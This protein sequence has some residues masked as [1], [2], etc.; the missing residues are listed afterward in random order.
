[1]RYT[2]IGWNFRDANVK[3]KAYSIKQVTGRGNNS[4]LII[5]L[6][7][8]VFSAILGETDMPP[9]IFWNHPEIDTWSKSRAESE[10]RALAIITSANNVR[11]FV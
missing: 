2:E 9:D 10:D 4:F 7:S 8:A 3:V 6:L 1:M 11:R 5:A